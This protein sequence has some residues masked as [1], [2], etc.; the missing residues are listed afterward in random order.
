MPF[1]IAVFIS[2]GG[3]TLANLIACQQAGR[4]DAEIALVLSSSPHAGGLELARQASIPTQTLVKSKFPDE[5][6]YSEAMFGLCRQAQVSLVVMAG[7]LKHVLIPEDFEN[8]VINIHPSL[9]PA[10]CGAGMYGR[11]VHQAVIDFGSRISGC[12]VHFVDNEYDHGP[13]LLQQACEVA[14]GDSAESL[15][16]RV[17]QHECQALPAAINLIARRRVSIDGRRVR[18]ASDSGG[19]AS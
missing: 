15:A 6:S 9:I 5:R 14:D 18:I 19:P 12:T 10:F 17:F 13:I 11:K 8:R 4:L 1:P 7:F 16:S 2:G 3:T